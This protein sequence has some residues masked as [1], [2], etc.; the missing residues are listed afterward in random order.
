M[1]DCSCREGEES[2]GK[3][4]NLDLKKEGE[5][6]QNLSPQTKMNELTLKQYCTEQKR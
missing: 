4:N 3:E 2:A 6:A 1:L 5:S